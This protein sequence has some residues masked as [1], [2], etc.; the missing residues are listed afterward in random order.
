MLA[1]N[2][3]K[4]ENEIV[5]VAPSKNFFHDLKSKSKIK[6]LKIYRL[7]S[8]PNPFRSDSRIG[9]LSQHRISKIIKS[10]KPDIVHIQAP[11]DI[12]EATLREAKKHHIPIVVTNHFSME[13]LLSYVRFLGPLQRLVEEILIYRFRDFYNQSDVVITPTK[14]V[15]DMVKSWGVKTNLQVISNGIPTDR[16]FKGP[17]DINIYRKY[18]IPDDKPIILCV[19]RIDSDKETDVV[20]RAM[21]YILTKKAAHLVIVGKG[22]LEK[23]C[24]NLANQLGIDDKITFTGSIAYRSSDLPQMYR[25]ASLFVVPAVGETQNIAMLEAMAT[26]LPIVAVKAG[27]MLELIINGKNG[28]LFPPKDSKI[29]AEKVVAVLRNPKLTQRFSQNNLK[30][31]LKHDQIAIHKQIL[32][33]YKKV[34]DEKNN[35]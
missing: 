16:F 32:N 17:A 1:E 31:A 24:K 33:L 30:E 10:F 34:I 13:S 21:P 27:A 2:L 6:G 12:G 20:I 7:R 23:D 9:L 28:L 22:D 8:V 5:I 11:A 19:G 15:A 25:I 29:L 14:I 3:A 18:Q 26:G 35:L 4:M